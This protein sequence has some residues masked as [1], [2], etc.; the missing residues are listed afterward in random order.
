M[1]PELV[2]LT[3]DQDGNIMN[4]AQVPDND[5]LSGDFF[6]DLQSGISN[7][8]KGATVSVSEKGVNVTKQDSFT[9]P[10]PVSAPVDYKKPLILGGAVV[11][12]LFLLTRK[13]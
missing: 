3:G 8:F 5:F 9:N 4:I 11:L 7:I 1:H 10:A 2:I 6:S 12:A 13:K